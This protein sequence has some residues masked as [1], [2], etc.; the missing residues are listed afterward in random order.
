[1]SQQ[2]SPINEEDKLSNLTKMH[3]SLLNEW[4]ARDTAAEPSDSF[5]PLYD[6]PALTTGVSARVTTPL[7]SLSS[8][9]Q[10]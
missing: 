9:D 1:M 8:I 5:T 10:M 4:D 3:H 7:Y 2:M 6:K